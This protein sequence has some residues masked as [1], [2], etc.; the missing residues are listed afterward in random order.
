MLTFHTFDVENVKDCDYDYVQISFG[1][2][3]E[4]YCGSEIRSPIVS[5]GN[6]MTVIFNSDHS[7]NRRGFNAT[8]KAWD[9]SGMSSLVRPCQYRYIVKLRFKFAS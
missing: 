8:W 7:K 2:V 1:S 5:S 6:K 4:K 3:A 9:N